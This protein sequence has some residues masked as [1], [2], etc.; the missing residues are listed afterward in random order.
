MPKAN[1]SGSA[2]LPSEVNMVI[3]IASGNVRAISQPVTR[4]R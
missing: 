1:I 4:G 3:T 2:A